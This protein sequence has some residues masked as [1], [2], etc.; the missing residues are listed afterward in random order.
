MLATRNSVAQ[1]Q[2]NDQAA[3]RQ[4]GNR[5]QR[6]P[7]AIEFRTARC[8]DVE[9]IVEIPHQFDETDSGEGGNQADHQSHQRNRRHAFDGLMGGEY[10]CGSLALQN[11]ASIRRAVLSQTLLVCRKSRIPSQPFSRP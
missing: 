5:N 9:D 7:V 3:T 2:A 10:H 4:H 1:R 6:E 8:A 11:G